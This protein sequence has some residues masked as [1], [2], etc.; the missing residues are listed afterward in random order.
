MSRPIGFKHTEETKVK[1]RARRHT[2]ETKHKLSETWK[3]VGHPKGMLGKHHSEETKTKMRISHSHQLNRPHTPEEIAKMS[4]GKREWDKT[5][6]GPMTGKHHSDETRA[7]LRLLQAGI[8]NGNWKGGRLSIAQFIRGSPK[9]RRLIASTLKRDKNTCQLCKQMGSDL[10]VDHI[11]PFTKIL[12][13][14]LQKYAV[15]DIRVFSFELYLIAL[16][17]KPFWDKHNMRTLCKKCNQDRRKSQWIYT[18][19]MT[20]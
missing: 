7:K 18:Q 20:S 13:G 14:F 9:N 1:L 10:E 6:P 3:R 11:K 15:L 16:K 12:D 8:N 4:K 5:H 17:Y 2:E 19:E